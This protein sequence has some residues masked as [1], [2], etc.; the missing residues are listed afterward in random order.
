MNSRCNAAW[1]SHDHSAEFAAGLDRG[2]ELSPGDLDRERKVEIVAGGIIGVLEARNC[3]AQAMR[4]PA[5]PPASE[6]VYQAI[7][8]GTQSVSSGTDSRSGHDHAPPGPAFGY[9]PPPAGRLFSGPQVPHDRYSRCGQPDHRADLPV[10]SGRGPRSARRH[11]E[12]AGG[13]PVRRGH[14][15]EHHRD[16]AGDG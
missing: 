11:G 4:P 7:G 16:W 5:G 14:G 15:R 12:P 8:G 6:P 13:A 9:L 1:H 10:L 2:T 3:R